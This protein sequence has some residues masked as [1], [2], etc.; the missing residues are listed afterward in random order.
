[1]ALQEEINKIVDDETAA[2]EIFGAIDGFDNWYF[3]EED[4]RQAWMPEVGVDGPD[5]LINAIGEIYDRNEADAAD[6][7]EPFPTGTNKSDVV[8][9][10]AAMVTTWKD[11]WPDYIKAS[12][13]LDWFLSAGE[14]DEAYIYSDYGDVDKSPGI[15]TIYMD[16]NEPY[17]ED[18]TNVDLFVSGV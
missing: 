3:D 8:S 10:L 15:D 1:M 4:Y 14:N 5:G 11:W 12:E 18:D 17:G 6:V 16:E 7:D 2:S 13:K 9:R